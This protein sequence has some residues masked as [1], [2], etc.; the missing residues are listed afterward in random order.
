[1]GRIEPE[2]CIRLCNLGGVKL[3]TQYGRTMS[4]AMLAV[5]YPEVCQKKTGRR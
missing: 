1:M 3:C 5:F 4:A 2:K